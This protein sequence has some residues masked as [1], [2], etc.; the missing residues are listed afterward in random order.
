MLDQTQTSTESSPEPKQHALIYQRPEE[1]YPKQVEAIFDPKRISVIEA[2][3]KSGK[4]LGSICWLYEE[5]FKGRAGENFWWVAPVASQSKIAFDRMRR[6]ITER[7][8][9]SVHLTDRT[10]TL[11]N[12][13]IIRFLS[14]DHADTL[15]GEDVKAC[16]IDEASRF[17]EDAWPGRR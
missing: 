1:L 15:Y 16:V 9:F 17:K 8:T 10:I 5:A 3:T 6:M 7:E 11:M 14:G 12:G 4:T 2:S 13:A